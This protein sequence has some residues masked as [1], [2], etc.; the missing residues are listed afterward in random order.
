M[1]T[2]STPLITPME[3]HKRLNFL[4]SGKPTYW[5][6]DPRKLPDLID[7]A[8]VRKIP[9]VSSDHS[10]VLF[11]SFWQPEIKESPR[12]LTTSATNWLKYKKHVSTHK[13]LTKT[14]RN[15][16]DKEH[17]RYIKKL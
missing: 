1:A 17:R 13:A 8:I 10:P 3:K 12:H 16:K 9:L 15:E 11:N 2:G 4:S 7:F 6:T 14:I 5:P